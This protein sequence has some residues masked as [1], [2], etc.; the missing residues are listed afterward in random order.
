[1]LLVLTLFTR[2]G[3]GNECVRLFVYLYDLKLYNTSV[4]CR[5]QSYSMTLIQMLHICQIKMF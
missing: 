4:I 5:I 3:R 1:M 2:E